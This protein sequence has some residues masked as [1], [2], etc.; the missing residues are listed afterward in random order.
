M[1][2]ITLSNEL[3]LEVDPGVTAVYGKIAFGDL[4][5]MFVADLKTWQRDQYERQWKMAVARIVDGA[6][7]SA[8]ILTYVE[9]LFSHLVWL[10]PL[11]REGDKVYT[12]DQEICFDQSS[13]PFSTDRPWDFLPERK[14]INLQGKRILEWV[15]N[16]ESLSEFLRKTERV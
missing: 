15:T 12:P 6:D 7:V 3:V 13:D 9:P 14:R 8:L 10:R 16:V 11:Y 4:S 2:N 1:F 5:A